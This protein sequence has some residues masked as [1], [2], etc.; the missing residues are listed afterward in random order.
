MKEG[1][2]NA[3]LIGR[4]LDGKLDPREL[5]IAQRKG[6]NFLKEQFGFLKER[7]IR[8][9]TKTDEAYN[10]I[11]RLASKEQPTTTARRKAYAE[12][13][14][15]LTSEERQAFQLQKADIKN[16]LPH[17]FEREQ[18]ERY[19]LQEQATYTA[20]LKLETNPKKINRYKKRLQ[21]IGENLKKNNRGELLTYEDLPSNITTGFL[22][23]RK[24][25]TGYS[26]DALKAYNH[27]VHAFARKIY[28]EPMLKHVKSLHPQLP[29]DLKGYN[30]W[31]IRNFM[32]F[33]KYALA[34]LASAIVSIQWIRTMGLNPRSAIVNFTQRLNTIAEVGAIYS[35]K[36]EAFAFTA[37][38][39][40]LF[41]ETGIA[42]EI[43]QVILEGDVK[44]EWFQT[45][46]VLGGFMF[47]Q[48]EKGNRR[49]AYLSAYLKAKD[50]KVSIRE[51]KRYGIKDPKNMTEA[52]I[53]QYSIDVVHRTQFRYGK[54]GMP[55]ALQYPL[56]RV[57]GQ[58]TSFTI[59]QIELM[60][61]WAKTDPMKLIKYM[62]MAEGGN[63]AV[64]KFL[65]TDLSNAL[66]MGVNWSDILKSLKAIPEG[67]LRKAYR[68][69]RLAFSSGSGIR[70]TGLGPT[71]VGI[72][73]VT[74]ALSRG[75]GWK[76]LKKELSIIQFKRL[77][78]GYNAIKNRR[79][80]SFPI[81]S[82]DGYLMYYDT[83]RQ[84]FQRTFG[85]MVAEEG[86]KY[87]EY[88]EQ[89]L[90]RQDYKQILNEMTRSIVDGDS[91]KTDKLINRYGIMPTDEQILNEVYRREL[92]QDERKAMQPIGKPEIFETLQKG[93]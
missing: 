6:Y 36:G 25:Y 5:N 18:L 49:H 78:Q 50:G 69:F 53:R 7:M 68:N 70:P 60:V 90:I 1:S 10:K 89:R 47:N 2:L 77:K 19:L 13:I 16:Y 45:V 54:V 79:G 29:A 40:R 46:K 34:D 59:K 65:D 26:F 71:A 41:D 23:Q 37:E 72:F 74:Q 9:L 14:K 21:K 62:A 39:K 15:N 12:E 22:K 28:Y 58:F 35:A 55:R 17:I 44:A 31:Y 87:R 51:A 33:E 38:G 27:Y 56:G 67:D 42:R 83:G 81:Y 91:K 93:E 3:D 86:E 8:H 92:T 48:M 24:G 52:E 66:G 84:L 4:A 73:K 80:N 64:Q 11:I 43:P 30:K 75:E 61:H 76:Q 82:T 32:G 88:Q 63:L 85:P 57:A 20:K